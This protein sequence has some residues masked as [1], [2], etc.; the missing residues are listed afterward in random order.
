MHLTVS[1]VFLYEEVLFRYSQDL[2]EKS[3]RQLRSSACLSK[4]CVGTRYYLCEG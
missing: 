4:R 1:L 2:N 3:A